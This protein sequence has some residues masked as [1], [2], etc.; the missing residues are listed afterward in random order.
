MASKNLTE[1]QEKFCQALVETGNASEAYRRAYNAEKMKENTIG[2][3]A[4]ALL[5][6]NKIT[7][8]LDELH[9]FHREQHNITVE[10]L[11]NYYMAVFQQHHQKTP[12]AAVSALNG[13][14]KIHG[15][16]EEHVRHS[17]SIEHDHK[18]RAISETAAFINDALGGGLEAA[19]E[20]SRTH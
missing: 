15:L 14:A 12:S 1:K 2:R 8:R 18:H 13:I 9:E 11:T 4:F 3:N 6:N 19:H 5:Q 20:E 17:G 10:K 16:S 7:T